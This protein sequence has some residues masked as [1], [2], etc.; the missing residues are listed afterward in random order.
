LDRAAFQLAVARSD[1]HLLLA[2]DRD[3]LVNLFQIFWL[4]VPGVIASCRH[5]S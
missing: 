5:Q 3:R 2:F 4:D 1:G